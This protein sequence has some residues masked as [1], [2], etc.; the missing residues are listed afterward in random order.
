MPDT[1][2][3]VAVNPTTGYVYVTSQG[4]ELW[5]ANGDSV[6][7]TVAVS[8]PEGVAVDPTT[9]QV[10]VASN[11]P[12]WLDLINGITGEPGPVINLG[13]GSYPYGVAID[14]SA[15]SVFVT[16]SGSKSVVDVDEATKQVVWGVSVGNAPELVAV[17]PLTSRLY[18]T[19]TN[20]NTV[21][22]IDEKA[23][24]V[25]STL[26][27][28]P[29]LNAVNPGGLA[30]NPSTNHIFVGTSTGVT[31]ID[32]QT[33][34]VLT[35]ISFSDEVAEIAVNPSTNRA[36]VAVDGASGSGYVAVIQDQ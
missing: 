23:E 10:Y 35:T 31:V 28:P 16:D 2:Q 27:V 11:G 9:S 30:V 4:G 8:Y 6:L 14:S 17:N 29:F 24:A 34:A 32:G 21:S 12:G 33:D 22:V 1:P 25:L 19:N 20:D 15:R 13:A 26:T 18:V 7:Y 3:E 5:I 36:Y